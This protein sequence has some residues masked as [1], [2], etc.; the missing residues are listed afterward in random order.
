MRVNSIIDSSILLRVGNYDGMKQDYDKEIVSFTCPANWIDY[1]IKHHN[2]ST[3]DMF[4]CAFAHVMFNDPRKNVKN[5]KGELLCNNLL[6]Y[7]NIYDLTSYLY[8][9][10]TIMMPVL[11]F[12]GRNM[13]EDMGKGKNRPLIINDYIKSMGYTKETAGVLIIRNVNEFVERLREGIPKA[14]V[15][16]NEKLTSSRFSTGFDPE[17]PLFFGKVDYSRIDKR[18]LFYNYHSSSI[19]EMFVK[20][21]KYRGQSEIRFVV[22]NINFAHSY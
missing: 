12:Y 7:E 18:G 4:E 2:T 17:S 1:E 5:S 13:W 14:V 9:M 15:E 3:G 20:D 11:C 22:P 16:Q 10:S 19:D 6:V 8:K 21:G